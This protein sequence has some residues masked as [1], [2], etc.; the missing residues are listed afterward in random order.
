MSLAFNV[1]H[2]HTAACAAAIVLSIVL[3][4]QLTALVAS[5]R[6]CRQGASGTRV[7]GTMSPAMSSLAEFGRVTCAG[8]ATLGSLPSSTHSAQGGLILA[9]CTLLAGL[10]GVHERHQYLHTL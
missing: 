7:C 10:H 2:A 3:S 8:D 6:S 5:A 9:I 4:L 1:Q